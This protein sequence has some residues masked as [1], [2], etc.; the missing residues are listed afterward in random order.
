[1]NANSSEDNLT[2]N[3]MTVDVEDFFQVSA[4]ERYIA[5]ENWEKYT[6]RVEANT[7][8]ILELFSNHDVRATFFTLGWVAE[9]YPGLVRRIVEQ[10]HDLASHGWDHK[11]VTTL[12]RTEFSADIRQAKAVLE[13][14]SGTVVTGYRA[15]SY[16]FTLDNDWAH[17]VLDEQGYEYSSSIAPIKHDLYG[18]PGAPR[19]AHHC[20]EDRVLELPITTARIMQ[21]NYPCGGGGWFRLYPYAVSKWAIGRVN[22]KDRQAAIF[23]FHPW[24]IDPQQPRIKGVDWR[25]KFRHYQ[26]LESMELKVGRLLADFEWNTIPAV[27]SKELG[28]REQRPG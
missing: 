5:R 21:K 2:I 27:F 8:R 7:D 16:S 3:A 1:M 26:N 9:R 23:Y 6:G 17:A 25:T 20:A 15:P 24:E 28:H 13:D 19:F 11:R 10:G 14:V 22:K 4:F 12:S 18:I